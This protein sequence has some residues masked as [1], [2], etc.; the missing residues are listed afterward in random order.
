MSL[1]DKLSEQEEKQNLEEIVTQRMRHL[2]VPLYNEIVPKL[3]DDFY[4]KY[5]DNY[6]MVGA[7]IAEVRR[8]KGENK[9]MKK[10]IRLLEE[11]AQIEIKELLK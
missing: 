7:C 6:L 10:R 4:N 3:T 5:L 2:L 8:I 1:R 11:S 9:R